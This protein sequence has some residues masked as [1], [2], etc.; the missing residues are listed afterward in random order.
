MK[1]LCWFLTVRKFLNKLILSLKR[2]PFIFYWVVCVSS[3]GTT[4][5]AFPQ[6]GDLLTEW[7]YAMLNEIILEQ[8][9]VVQSV[10]I[11][12]FQLNKVQL[13]CFNPTSEFQ[14]YHKLDNCKKKKNKK[15][16]HSFNSRKYLVNC[17]AY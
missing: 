2:L 9:V 10:V 17:L 14:N 5:W 8:E 6:L 4:D 13:Q 11:I 3:Q 1:T 7:G 12:K 16:F 15:T